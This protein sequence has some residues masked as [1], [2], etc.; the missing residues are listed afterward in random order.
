MAYREVG[1]FEVK[2]ILRLYLAGVPKKAVSR[3]VGSDIKTVRRYTKAAEEL[4]LR[5]PLNDAKLAQLFAFLQMGKERER[6]QAYLACQKHSE[7]IKKWLDSGVRLTK[8]RKLLKRIQR[9]DVPYSTLHRYAVAELEFGRRGRRSVRIVD[10]APGQELQIDTGWVVTLTVGQKKVRKKAFIFAP[11][12]SRY[13]FVYPIESETTT[14]A[15]EACE[16]AWTFYG[17]IFEVLLPDNT[18]AIVE[19]A[20]STS[21]LINE[22]FREYAQERGFTVDPAR[23]R[24]PKDK[25]R[26]EKTVA[27][28]R[29]D[30]FGGEVLG[31]IE[32]ARVRALFWAEHEAGL[33]PHGT[34]KRRPKEHFESDEG[35]H[36][37]PAPTEPYDIP[38]W[39]SV[40]V[41]HTQH[42]AAFG[43]LYMLPERMV[44][45]RLRARADQQLVR[46]YYRNTLIKVL[47]RAPRGGRSFDKEDIPEHKRAY[48]LRDEAFLA[49]QARGHAEAIGDFADRLLEGPAPWT[50]MRRVSALLSLVRRFGKDRVEQACRRA[51]DAQMYDVDRLR[52]MVEQH[53]SGNE[54][55]TEHVAR[56]IPIARY[57]R[58][59][60]TW[61]INK[62]EGETP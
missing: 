36:L 54:V 14:A 62:D 55:Q 12:L 19:K 29:D 6:G 9:I 42:V 50:R 10:A 30:C 18:K 49:E 41:D 27:F 1:V 7:A 32:A 60:N 37:K 15:I 23:V 53:S 4:E 22:V 47:P 31:S 38:L 3:T 17:G 33:T 58:P 46:F 56:I 28:V 61:A 59:A 51:L 57:L 20:S 34:T 24:K 39:A 26:V 48:A 8:I 43:A 45:N 44:R 35:A 40:T 52:R 21:P 11:N 16:A 13:R 25:A 5:P 2:E